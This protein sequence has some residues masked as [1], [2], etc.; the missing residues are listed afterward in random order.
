[1]DPGPSADSAKLGGCFIDDI[2]VIIRSALSLNYKCVVLDLGSCDHKS[3]QHALEKVGVVHLTSP[4]RAR[5]VT[6]RWR[7][8]YKSRKG[9]RLVLTSYFT[10]HGFRSAPDRHRRLGSWV[11]SISRH[12][13][14][15]VVLHNGLGRK[16]VARCHDK[17]PHLD[18]EL[19]SLPFDFGRNSTC[20]QSV[21][22]FADYLERRA[23]IE[24]VVVMDLERSLRKNVF[25]A[26][27]AL[28][29][30]LYSDLDIMAFRDVFT[31]PTATE[32]ESGENSVLLG[33]SLVLGGSRHLV[34]ATLNK[35][36]DC[37]QSSQSDD[38]AAV[39]KCL[40]DRHLV[41][42]AFMGWPLSSAV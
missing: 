3:S 28:G 40:M 30:W 8:E 29:D 38:S 17:Y 33:D 14:G 42:H 15:G 16:F 41:Q 9:S 5:A 23:D 34:L 6:D 27:E 21:L 22:A 4:A 10:G 26:I 11:E 19:V 31:Q 24:S 32:T 39:L 1:M 36:A 37:L 2:V 35:M 25:P 13:L 7:N 12:G 20:R 18:F